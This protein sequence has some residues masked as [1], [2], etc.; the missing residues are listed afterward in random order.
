M[1]RRCIEKKTNR[2]GSEEGSFKL[3]IDMLYLP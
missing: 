2:S 3:A 1:S